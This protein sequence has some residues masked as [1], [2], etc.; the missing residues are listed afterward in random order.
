MKGLLKK[1]ILI[2]RVNKRQEYLYKQL[3]EDQD[4]NIRLV[5]YNINEGLVEERILMYRVNK[6]QAYPY[7]QL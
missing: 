2:Y 5:E 7:K 1:R 4:T 6:R 3:V